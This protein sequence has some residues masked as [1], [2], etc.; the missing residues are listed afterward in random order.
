MQLN[1]VA[2]YALVTV[3]P[4]LPQTL[5]GDSGS[6]RKGNL[7]LREAEEWRPDS[8]RRHKL[9]IPVSASLVLPGAGQFLT[10]HY[11]K[12]AFF[13]GAEAALISSVNFWFK[14]AK[15]DAAA[16]AGYADIA[17]R[18]GEAGD[19]LDSAYLCE[20]SFLSLRSAFE[21]R[22]SAYSFLSWA[23]GGY[24]FNAL[25]AVGCTNAF[26]NSTPRSPGKAGLLAAIPG[27][28]LGQLYNGSI[29]K[30]GMVMMTQ[31][32]LGIMAYSSQRLMNRAES[33]YGRLK[34]ADADSLT[35]LVALQH[36]E[37]WNA[38]RQRAFTSRNIYLWYSIFFYF[39]GIFDAVVDAYLH[40]YQQRMKIAPDLIVE[41]DGVRF[42]IAKQF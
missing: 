16:A 19:R 6:L 25:D 27:L 20:Q 17:K 38:A 4:V 2:L 28:G 3:L 13:A 31:V 26:K 29:G 15:A 12:A 5:A 24:V 21:A 39:Y 35:R 10:G 14:T 7:L 11:V 32:S 30:A 1:K 41:R 23:I 22:L 8:V 36:A 42:S 37:D 34:S 18:A 33:N 9:L 40:D